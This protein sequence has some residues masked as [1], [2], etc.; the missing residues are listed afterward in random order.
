MECFPLI[1]RKCEVPHLCYNSDMPAT[2]P[3]I[4]VV[5]DRPLYGEI[6]RRALRDGLS[7]SQEARK[8]LADA[9][10]LA[11]DAELDALVEQRRK[12][13]KRSFSLAEVKRQLKI[14]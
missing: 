2:Q 3:R 14:R 7:L 11:E 10:E 4:S 6:R 8:L 12:T 5:V 1:R 9:A 13:S